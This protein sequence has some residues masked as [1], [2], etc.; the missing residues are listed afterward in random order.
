MKIVDIIKF[1]QFCQGHNGIA[2]AVPLWMQLFDLFDF[3]CLFV[4]NSAQKCGM[5]GSALN[6]ALDPMGSAFE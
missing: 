5:F 1:V 6:C 2:N 3:C 4:S